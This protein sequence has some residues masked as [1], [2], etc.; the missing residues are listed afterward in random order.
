[1]SSL[2][3]KRTAD[4]QENILNLIGTNPEVPCP[5]IEA[6]R[7]M[8]E[9]QRFG[10]DVDAG[11]MPTS[12]KSFR[13]GVMNKLHKMKV[14]LSAEVVKRNTTAPSADLNTEHEQGF[15]AALEKKARKN[16]ALREGF[17]WADVL[18]PDVDVH[19]TMKEHYQ[20]KSDD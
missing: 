8:T 17:S 11:D 16:F 14:A 2:T 5:V 12:C 1:M 10:A 13:E 6:N 15:I 3:A 19:A 18:G 4:H 9:F 20:H 7:T